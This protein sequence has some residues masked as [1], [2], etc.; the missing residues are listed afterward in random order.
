MF[1]YDNLIFQMT[2]SEKLKVEQALRDQINSLE[3]SKSTL[4]EEKLILEERVAGLDMALGTIRTQLQQQEQANT[5][6]V[7][8]GQR[9]GCHVIRC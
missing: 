6:K 9:L 7:L 5:R 2:V 3:V 1:S 8:I 4:E